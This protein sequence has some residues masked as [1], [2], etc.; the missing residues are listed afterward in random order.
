MFENIQTIIFDLDGTLYQDDNYHK[1]YLHNL[2]ENTGREDWE[3]AFIDFV[4]STL[5]GEH[6]KMNAFYLS[7]KLETNSLDSYFAQLEASEVEGVSYHQAL[8]SS[9]LIYLGDLWAL[10]N[11]LARTSGMLEVKNAYEV[12]KA[13][14]KDME[15]YATRGDE[16][17][18]QALLQAKKRYQTILFSNTD[19]PLG[20]SYLAILGFQDAFTHIVYKA[21]KPRDFLLNLEKLDPTILQ[22]P[23]SVL[24]IGDHG[25]NDLMPL[26]SVGGKTV[27]I[28]PYTG[29]NEPLYDIKLSSVNELTEFL[30]K[31]LS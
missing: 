22:R 26:Q 13:T 10:L 7:D 14:R 24:S 16:K 31:L 6:L 3:S 5:K 17:L 8:E 18:L 12:F 2:L 1:Y 19:E 23:K 20:S 9:N 30:N 15:T 27:W 4:E 25:F 28:N 21:N 11:L 29:I